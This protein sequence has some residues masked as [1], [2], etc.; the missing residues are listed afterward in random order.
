MDRAAAGYLFGMSRVRIVDVTDA[1]GFG[2]LPPC[3]DPAFDHRTCDYWEDA[4]RGSKAHRPGWLTPAAGASARGPSRGPGSANPFAPTR[5]AIANPFAPAGTGTDAFGGPANPFAAGPSPAGQSVRV[6][7]GRRPA[8]RQSVR[9]DAT[10]P[11][12]PRS[13]TGRASSACSRVGSPSSGASQRS[14]WSSTKAKSGRSRM[15][16]SG[17]SPRTRARCGSAS[18]TRGCR[19]RPCRP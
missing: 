16:S 6:R 19:R 9:A 1:A 12:R 17:R 5:S 2:R 8:G 11:A 13:R 15:P 4:D 18:S 10:L 7:R 3:A 14:S